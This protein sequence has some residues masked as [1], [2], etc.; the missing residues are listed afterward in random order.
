MGQNVVQASL[1]SVLGILTLLVY[2]ILMPLMV[3]FF[4]KDKTTIVTVGQALPAEPIGA[5]PAR[6]G[7]MWTCRSETTSAG[8]SSRS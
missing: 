7:R 5:S 8:S 6:S 1:S 4:L 2:L 3:F